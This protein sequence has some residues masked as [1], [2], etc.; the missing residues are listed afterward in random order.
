MHDEVFD[1]ILNVAYP[2]LAA[3]KIVPYLLVATGVA[4]TSVSAGLFLWASCR[5]SQV[6]KPILFYY[7]LA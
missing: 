4:I 6:S 1:Q 2:G 3:A 7:D 5:Q